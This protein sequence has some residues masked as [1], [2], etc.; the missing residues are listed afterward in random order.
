[1]A[2]NFLMIRFRI[3]KFKNFNF[4]LMAKKYS[5]C[6]FVPSPVC[7]LDKF[8]QGERFFSPYGK[9]L[10][11]CGKFNDIDANYKQKSAILPVQELAKDKLFILCWRIYCTARDFYHIGRKISRRAGTCPGH[12]PG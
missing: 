10:S 3:L 4:I 12:V 2:G 6:G 7:V 9:N 1:M 8:P 5:V 11:Q